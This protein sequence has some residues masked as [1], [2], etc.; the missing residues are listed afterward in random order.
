M[1]LQAYS[2]ISP[3]WYDFR[4]HSLLYCNMHEFNFVLGKAVYSLF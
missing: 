1:Q 4:I 2:Y 3:N